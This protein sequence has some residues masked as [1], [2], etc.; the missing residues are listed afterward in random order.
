M[1]PLAIPL[2][3]HNRYISDINEV[4]FRKGKCL[5]MITD[6]P[7]LDTFNMVYQSDVRQCKLEQLSTI[8]IILQND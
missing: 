2:D 7:D 1:K 3:R 6:F 8:R 4:V 5:V